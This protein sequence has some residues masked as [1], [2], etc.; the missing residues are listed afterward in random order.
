MFQSNGLPTPQRQFLEQ[1][2]LGTKGPADTTGDGECQFRGFSQSEAAISKGTI[3][4]VSNS[5][6]AQ[7][8]HAAA[9]TIAAVAIKANSVIQDGIVEFAD[10]LTSDNRYQ[11]C[12]Y[13]QALAGQ[14]VSVLPD[15]VADK[16]MLPISSGDDQA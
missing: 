11:G 3:W 7:S 13:Q 4:A 16:M 5:E 1:I 9:R 2:G 14:D 15:L 12:N 6:E 8:D 10:Q